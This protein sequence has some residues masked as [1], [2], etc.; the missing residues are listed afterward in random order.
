[1]LG[2]TGR[3]RQGTGLC[4]QALVSDNGEAELRAALSKRLGAP[5]FDLWFGDV[6]RLG[7]S[8]DGD[9]LEVHVP[10]SFFRD[11]I[12]AHYSTSLLDVAETITGRT[13]R[14]AIQVRDEAEP[15]LGDVVEPRPIWTEPEPQQPGP[16]TVPFPGDPKASPS[17]PASRPS[18]SQPPSPSRFEPLARSHTD[19]PTQRVQKT[20]VVTGSIPALG[21]NW[22]VRRLDN[23][24]IGPGNQ[25]AHAAAVEMSRSAGA[26]FNPLL[27]HSAVGLGKTH[28]LEGTGQALKQV[29]SSLNI[30]HTTAEAFTNSFLEAMRTGALNAFRARFRS[31]G[32]FIVDDVHFLAAKRATQEEFLHTFN[33]LA[34]KRTPIILATDQHPRQIARLSDELVTRFLA[35]MVVKIDPPDLA[36][37]RAILHARASL[38]GINLPDP[39]IA[40]IAEH[41]R[42]S[43]RELEGALHTVI[44]QATLIGRHIDLSLAQNALRDTIRHTAQAI[45]LRDVE[46]AVCQ[47]FQVNPEAL[48]SECRCTGRCLSPDARHV[49]G[50]QT[51]RCGLQRDRPALWR[52]QPFHCDCRGEK[53]P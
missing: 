15:P 5:R 43:V 23:F 42:T 46:R 20:G 34:A 44:A 27:I 11:W 14:L 4:A 13:P 9:A 16:I 24:V 41:V 35:G 51:R 19:Q 21:A 8:G 28:L 30:L 33:A 29:H 31:A 10:N 38:R 12:Q 26:V 17:L 25:L 53:S 39:V 37:R 2:Q 1:M 6:V 47:L 32:A 48:K 36:T 50:A 49:P 45:A 40:Y 18:T 22:I 7:L 3:P 52:T